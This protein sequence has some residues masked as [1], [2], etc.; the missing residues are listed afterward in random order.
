MKAVVFLLKKA[1]LFVIPIGLWLK[2]MHIAFSS[3][4]S[5]S[6]YKFKF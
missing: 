1:N 6:Y 5:H 4:F 3:Y 2:T